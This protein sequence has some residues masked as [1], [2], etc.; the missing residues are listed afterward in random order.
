MLPVA[1]V[2]SLS[3]VGLGLGMTCSGPSIQKQEGHI[4]QAGSLGSF[5]GLFSSAFPIYEA[6]EFVNPEPGDRIVGE[7]F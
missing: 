3:C 1:L 6:S 5:A 4:Q 2:H 7:S